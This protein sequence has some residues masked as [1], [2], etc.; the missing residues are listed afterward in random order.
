[1][2][3]WGVTNNRLIPLLIFA[4]LFSVLPFIRNRKTAW[5]FATLI[6]MGI[7]FLVFG[8]G[9]A[10]YIRQGLG[11]SHFAGRAIIVIVPGLV[12]GGLMA[13]RRS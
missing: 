12:A 6:P 9:Q 10:P 1:M 8:M 3:F 5:I 11:L 13:F 7:T 4:S 2:R